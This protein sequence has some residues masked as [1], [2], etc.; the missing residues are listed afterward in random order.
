MTFAETSR[1]RL[2]LACMTNPLEFSQSYDNR[3][4]VDGSSTRSVLGPSCSG[5]PSC[6]SQ[7]VLSHWSLFSADYLG[8]QE[9]LYDFLLGEY[10][11]GDD[12]Q[13]AK[14][15]E[16][17]TCLEVSVRRCSVSF[18]LWTVSKQEPLPLQA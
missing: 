12:Q 6:S 1:E 15:T 18:P 16:Y 14:P 13:F 8:L 17:H 10:V 4:Q 11:Q 2:Q 5:S 9:A 7:D 3:I